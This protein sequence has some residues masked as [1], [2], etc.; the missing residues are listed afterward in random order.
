MVRPLMQSMNRN[1]AV[2][3]PSSTSVR[4]EENGRLEPQSHGNGQS[5]RHSSY[6]HHRSN[7][8]GYLL[9]SDDVSCTIDQIHRE[10]TNL[11]LWIKARTTET[12]CV[13]LISPSNHDILQCAQISSTKFF[14][15]H[16]TASCIF[17]QLDLFRATFLILPP[18]RRFPLLYP[19]TLA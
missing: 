19:S 11:G 4:A 8:S 13:L 15:F 7:C 1:S 10:E 3:T 14:E 6:K 17:H 16:W 2:L 12:K 5:I 9:P 18:V